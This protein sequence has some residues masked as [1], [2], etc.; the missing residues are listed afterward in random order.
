MVDVGCVCVGG[1]ERAP[2]PQVGEGISGSQSEGEIG[3]QRPQEGFSP[4]VLLTLLC[5]WLA[6]CPDQKEVESLP[7]N[8]RHGRKEDTRREVPELDTEEFPSPPTHTPHPPHTP[9]LYFT[10]LAMGAVNWFW[11]QQSLWSLRCWK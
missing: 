6:M 7:G 10:S 8:G 11:G 1:G 3:V 4:F 2:D 5:F 9:I